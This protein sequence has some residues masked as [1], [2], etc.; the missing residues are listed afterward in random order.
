MNYA[1]VYN[2]ERRRDPKCGYCP[3]CKKANTNEAWCNPCDRKALVDKFNTWSTGN[4]TLDL[5]IQE[6]QRTATFYSWDYWDGKRSY[7]EYVPYDRFT[8]VKSL[9][10]GGFARVFTATWLDGKR[11]LKE[12][13]KNVDYVKGRT[14]PFTV[15][16]KVIDNSA[17]M[18]QS[19]INEVIILTVLY[20]F[21]F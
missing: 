21:S 1:L 3:Q 15:A 12:V 16:L 4:K 9:A 7:L 6:T 8:D 17:K 5:F 11:V 13:K 10:R 14:E 18:E 20:C 19:F 2:D